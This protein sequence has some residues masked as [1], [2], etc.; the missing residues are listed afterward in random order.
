MLK[1]ASSVKHWTKTLRKKNLRD[2][3]VGGLDAELALLL[4]IELPDGDLL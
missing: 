4:G 3:L 2:S 1:G